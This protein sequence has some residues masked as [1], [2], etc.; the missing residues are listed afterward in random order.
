MYKKQLIVI[1]M[2][3]TFV[4]II[5]M[6]L[7]SCGSAYVA[8]KVEREFKGDWVLESVTFPD[9]SGFFDVEL[10]EVADISCFQN[11]IWKFVPNNSTGE[12]TLDGDSCAKTKN[13]LTWY[14]DSET[15]K[16]TYPE[17]LMKVTTGQKAKDVSRGTRIR[18][19]SLLENEMVWEQKTKFNNKEIK[20]EM[21]FTKI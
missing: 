18:I 9:S 21:T 8:N 15:A 19:K 12:F 4:L 5:S 14:V 20:V 13:R 11:S 1:T 3:Y 7:T 6:L 17:V 2:K 16:N 10:F